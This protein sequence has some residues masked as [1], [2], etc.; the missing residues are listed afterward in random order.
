MHVLNGKK[1]YKSR[2]LHDYDTILTN[3]QI[4]RTEKVRESIFLYINSKFFSE[5]NGGG[6]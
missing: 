3:F 2:M 4:I 1:I 6:A 5:A